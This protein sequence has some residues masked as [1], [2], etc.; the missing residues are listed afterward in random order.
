MN[1]RVSKI[2]ENISVKIGDEILLE[3][4]K[5]PEKEKIVDRKSKADYTTKTD[6]LADRA[7]IDELKRNKKDLPFV[8]ISEE[9]KK[10][11]IFGDKGILYI[12][13][14]EGTTNAVFGRPYF[15]VT[16]SL[17]ENGIPTFFIFYTP[18]FKEIY[19]ATRKEGAKLNDEK[20]ESKNLI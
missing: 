5:K 20:S 2:L 19:K 3:N 16:M 18:C 10:P 6:L 15:G 14:R 11:M 4:F 8:I 17:F 1:R 9:R 13:P 12:D 7:I